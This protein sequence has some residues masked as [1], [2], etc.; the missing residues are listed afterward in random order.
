MSKKPMTTKAEAEKA[1]SHE[2]LPSLGLDEIVSMKWSGV[3]GPEH[4]HRRHHARPETEN[5][6]VNSTDA[7]R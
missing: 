3:L 6:R 1:V 7:P 2:M 5:G 4:G